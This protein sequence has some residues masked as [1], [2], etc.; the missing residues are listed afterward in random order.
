M[1][2]R[3]SSTA[4]SATTAS[5]VAQK[6]LRGMLVFL[7]GVFI[8]FVT[9]VLVNPEWIQRGV[10]ALESRWGQSLYGYDRSLGEKISV[11]IG[12]FLRATGG[13]PEI[14]ELVIDVPFMEMRKIYAA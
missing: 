9:T 5:S 14:P 3:P 8:F 10:T 11:V 1:K 12:S 2:V 13:L 4:R 7:M 6:L